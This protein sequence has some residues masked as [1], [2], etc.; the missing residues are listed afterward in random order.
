M[1]T[2]ASLTLIAI[3]AILAFAV[4]AS[5]PYFNVQ[6]AGYV[7]IVIGIVGLYLRQRGWIGRQLTIRRT[8]PIRTVSV[9]RHVPGDATGPAGTVPVGPGIYGPPSRETVATDTVESETVV[10]EP[11]A[12]PTERP[13]SEV[14]EEEYYE[15]PTGGPLS[16]GRGPGSP[17]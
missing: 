1:K 2:G 17:S 10:E 12:V 8:R 16:W 7:L 14:I 5:P 9:V 6:I 4:T 15:E 3:G 11:L 13:E